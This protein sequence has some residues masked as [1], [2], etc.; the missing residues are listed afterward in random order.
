MGA[1]DAYT[2]IAHDAVF[3]SA[4]T[5]NMIV[6][7]VKLFDGGIS[8]A[9]VNIPVWLGF[10]LGCLMAQSMLTALNERPTM[11]ERY[12]RLMLL[13]VAIL[14]VVAVGQN[15][16]NPYVLIVI[17]GWLSGYE[18][19]TFR[20]VKGSAIN[21]GI[22]TG[23]TKNLMTALYLWLYGHDQKAKH[24]FVWTG[25]IMLMFIFGAYISAMICTWV[26]AK[27]ILWLCLAINALGLIGIWLSKERVE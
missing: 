24:R 14:L 3:A 18:L 19:T 16:F 9:W 21:N 13:V 27:L 20:Q 7:A 10:A 1:I 2:Y 4:Q 5:G 23:N 12:S 25:L 22:M 26:S 6:F 15:W 8:R 11:R 17:L